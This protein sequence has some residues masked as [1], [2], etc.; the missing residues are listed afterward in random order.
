MWRSMKIL[1]R[2]SLADLIACSC[3]EEHPIAVEEAKTYIQYLVRAGYLRKMTKGNADTASYM[4]IRWTG[5]KAP[6][7]QRIKQVWDQNLK[8]VVWPPAGGKEAKA[9]DKGNE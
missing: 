2:F 8:V 9:K 1:K 6:M 7:I 4:M 5:P 3:T